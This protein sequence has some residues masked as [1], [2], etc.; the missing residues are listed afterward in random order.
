MSMKDVPFED[1]ESWDAR[2]E[3]ARA[4]PATNAA[5]TRAS[6]FTRKTT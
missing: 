1:E 2:E 6:A 4:T 3:A 5:K